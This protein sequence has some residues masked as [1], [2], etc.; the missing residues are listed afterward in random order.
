MFNRHN[1]IVFFSFTFCVFAQGQKKIDSLLNIRATSNVDSI[2]LKA[3]NKIASHYI[4]RDIKKAKAYA[5]EQQALSDKLN[6]IEFQIKASHHLAVIYNILSKHDSARFYIDKTIKL[7]KEANNLEQISISNH[8]LANLEISLG[9]LDK[10]EEIN[11]KN[12]EFNK[13]INDSMA[14]ALAYDLESSIFI[15]KEQYQLA[16]K[17]VLNSLKILENLNKK[18][19]IADAKNKIAIIE[20]SLENFD[21]SIEYSLQALK[22]YEEFEDIEYQSQICNILGISYKFK[23]DYDKAK[24]YFNRS[25]SISEPNDY[26]SILIVSKSHLIDIYMESKDYGAAK[27][28]IDECKEI[29]SS[30]GYDTM[31][32]YSNIR[33]AKYYSNI[34]LYIQTQE[35]L[36]QLL[37]NDKLELESRANIYLTKSETFKLQNNFKEALSNYEL[38]KKYQDS[39]LLRNNKSQIN[40]L[41]II[42]KTE[43]KEAEIILKEEEIKTLNAKAEND[44]LS[45]ILYGGG[46]IAGVLTSGLLF[47][48]FRQ[49]MKK[50]KIER[51]KQEEIYKQEIDFKK[52]ELASQTLHLVQKNTF[53]QELKENLEKIKKSPE[54]FKIEFRRLVMLLKKESAED[55]D[56]EVFKSYFSEVHNNFDQKIKSIA[57]D[58]TEK[59]IRLASFLR[60]NL[61]TKEIASMLNVLPDS[62][63]KSKY[64]LKKKLALEK[65]MDLTQFLNS[66]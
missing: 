40:E 16:L 8:S 17:S 33:L 3:I 9:N 59:E 45:K 29:A 10:A 58:I 52:K 36:N 18:I 15:Q 35:L 2:K 62:V 49:R 46:A 12:L 47:F 21:S 14:I 22:I 66:L 13:A 37:M 53:I 20:N 4:Y 38:Y 54:L 23:K 63:L 31:I 5:Y 56:W 60:M 1:I 11:S 55:K 51:E 43:Q 44:K 42:H 34:G 28:L 41:R 27:K 57:G 26:L 6:K 30:I 19:R 48:G 64:R 65:D 32:T 25:I 61:T 7:S 50:N 24:E 39:T